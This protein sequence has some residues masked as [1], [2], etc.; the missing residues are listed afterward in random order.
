MWRHTP[1]KAA[2]ISPGELSRYRSKAASNGGGRPF[3]IACAIRLACSSVGE[4]FGCARLMCHLRESS[5]DSGDLRCSR[6][7]SMKSTPKPTCGF[8]RPE[9]ARGLPPKATSHDFVDW[10][11]TADEDGHLYEASPVK[12]FLRELRF[13]ASQEACV[14]FH[15]VMVPCLAVPSRSSPN[16]R[17]GCA[18][19]RKGLTAKARAER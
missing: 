12:R 4:D 6:S 14:C 15:G 18:F 13:L 19:G 16:A 11:A 5:N 1:V 10:R 17:M 3:A 8:R 7:K 9:A 2:K